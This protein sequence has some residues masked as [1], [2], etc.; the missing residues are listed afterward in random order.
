MFFI[1]NKFSLKK[2][3]SECYCVQFNDN[4]WKMFNYFQI[5]E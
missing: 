1:Y 3:I 5:D 4:Y 2:P